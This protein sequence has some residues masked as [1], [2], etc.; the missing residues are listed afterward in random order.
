MLPI[1]PGCRALYL[2]PKKTFEV[3]IS[4][5]FDED[6]DGY[7]SCRY[8][9]GSI[10]ETGWVFVEMADVYEGTCECRLLRIDG[11]KVEDEEREVVV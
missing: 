10:C 8:C 2:H 9:G 3:V 4:H 5:K 7:T 6:P 11:Y 1:V